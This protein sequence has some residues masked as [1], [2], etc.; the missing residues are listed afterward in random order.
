MKLKYGDN[1]RMVY[2]D[3]GSFAF[4]TRTDD[5]YKDLNDIKDEMEVSDYPISHKFYDASNKK[6]LGKFK[7]ELKSNLITGFIALRPKT[8]AYTVYGDEEDHK[9]FKGTAK[10]T[11]NR[12]L[13]DNDYDK[14]KT[15][16]R[17]N[18]QVIQ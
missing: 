6:T 11:V 12:S 9:T 4:H 3:T 14:G 1:I 17:R 2:T 15:N 5:T 7:D 13:T 10:N 16:K 8:Y 18:T